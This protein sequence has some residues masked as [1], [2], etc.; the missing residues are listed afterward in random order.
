M[1]SP[2]WSALTSEFRFEIFE[3]L[4]W[5]LIGEGF[6][7]CLEEAVSIDLGQFPDLFIFCRSR[8]DDTYR[9]AERRSGHRVL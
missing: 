5:G 8:D 3:S 6:V 7:L 9:G 2:K 1:Q 4:A